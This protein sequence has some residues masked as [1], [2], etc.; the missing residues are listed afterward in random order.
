MPRDGKRR[1][2]NGRVLYRVVDHPDGLGIAGR[3]YIEL[4]SNYI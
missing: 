1:R 4:K 3:G 2:G